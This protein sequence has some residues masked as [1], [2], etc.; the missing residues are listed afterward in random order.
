[1]LRLRLVKESRIIQT[2]GKM[3]IASNSAIVGAT[4]SQAIVRSDRPRTRRVA[5]DLA[6]SLTPAIVAS[7]GCEIVVILSMGWLVRLP[8]DTPGETSPVKR[9]P[10]LLRRDL[11]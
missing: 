7:S 10:C 3:L 4:N 11:L 2:S 5:R 9:G 6:G 1:M 8:R